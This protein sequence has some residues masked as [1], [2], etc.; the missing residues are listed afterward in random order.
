MLVRGFVFGYE[1]AVV[2]EELPPGGLV[3]ASVR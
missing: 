3:E 2:V 1:G